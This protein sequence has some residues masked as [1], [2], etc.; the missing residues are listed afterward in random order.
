[1]ETLSDHAQ[2][3]I[4]RDEVLYAASRWGKPNPLAWESQW[5]AIETLANDIWSTKVGDDERLRRLWVTLTFAVGNFKR[6]GG[7]VI[8]PLP[9]PWSLTSLPGRSQP[10]TTL[11]VPVNGNILTLTSDGTTADLAGMTS[12]L[13]SVPTGSTLLSAL[14]PRE[15]VIMD[16]RDFQVAVGLLACQGATVVVP[17]EAAS[18]Y[19]PDWDEYR[20][21]RLLIRNEADRLKLDSPMLLERALYVAY[22][23]RTR[24]AHGMPW[25]QWGAAL[26]G[27]WHAEAL[28]DT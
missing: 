13:S 4:T 12:G 11:S 8:S 18:L 24:R 10:R 19:P 1:L 5:L 25:A 26:K 15:N 22:D 9:S 20:W 28:R 14:W 7:T 6:Q 27:R 21:F 3:P 16:M 2:L 17:N 23:Y